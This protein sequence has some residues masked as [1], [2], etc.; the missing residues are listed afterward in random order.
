LEVVVVW[1]GSSNPTTMRLKSM[2]MR[3]AE[4]KKGTNPGSL[5]TLMNFILPT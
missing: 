3:M 4:Q 1:S 5:V 2:K